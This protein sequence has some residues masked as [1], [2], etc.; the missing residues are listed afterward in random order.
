MTS[1]S[2]YAKPRPNNVSPAWSPDGEQIVFLS[3]RSGKWEFYVKNADGSNQRQVLENVT[4]S[5]DI[6]Y[7]GVYERVISWGQ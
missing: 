1:S 2:N 5:L 3:D 6:Q 4:A 7:T